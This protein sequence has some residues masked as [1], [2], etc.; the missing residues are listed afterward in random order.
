MLHLS[1]SNILFVLLIIVLLL[2]SGAM[3]TCDDDDDDAANTPTQSQGTATPTP[4]PGAGTP[5]ATWTPGQGA[6]DKIIDHRCINQSQIPVQWITAVKT[7]IRLHYAHTSHGQQLMSGLDIIHQNDQSY[8]YWIDYCALPVSQADF[9][10]M[11]GMPDVG[12]YSCETYATPEY[13]WESQDGIDWV[14]ATLSN[15][16]VN[17]SM[18]CW[19]TQLDYYT[20]SQVQQ[21]LNTINTLESEY[22]NVTFVYFT[23]NAQSQEQNRYDRNQQIREYCRNNNKWL[24]D[25]ADMDCWYNNEQYTVGGIPMEHPHYSQAAE[26]DGHTSLENCRNKGGGTWWLMARI[27][28]WDGQ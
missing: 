26:Y 22:P 14:R 20:S 1:K 4:T 11:D 7:N 24:F 15:F 17:V 5:T 6:T 12:D 28:G 10:I 3:I 8:S 16:N 13:Y 25:F 18:W 19:C 21:Y 9:T 23:G 2:F 27:A